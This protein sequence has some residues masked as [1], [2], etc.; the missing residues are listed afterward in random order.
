MVVCVLCGHREFR[1]EIGV[2]L[3]PALEN[4]V[5]GCGVDSFFLGSQGGFDRAALVALR[6]LKRRHPHISYTVVLA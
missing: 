6:E 5:A 4:L 1:E 3:L 2:G